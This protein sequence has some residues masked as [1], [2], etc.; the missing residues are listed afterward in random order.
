MHGNVLALSRICF[1]HS[2][3]LKV[4]ILYCL[5]LF[6]IWSDFSHTGE[7]LNNQQ[8]TRV[9]PLSVIPQLMLIYVNEYYSSSQRSD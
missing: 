8:L 9:C 7:T 2:I 4:D 5:N 3:G 6:I 1:T